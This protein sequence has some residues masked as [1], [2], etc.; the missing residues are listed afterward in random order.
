MMAHS[1]WF[2][3]SCL[4]RCLCTAVIDSDSLS[5]ES[6]VDRLRFSHSLYDLGIAELEMVQKPLLLFGTSVF[7]TDKDGLYSVPSVGVYNGALCKR[8]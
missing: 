3:N 7:I 4:F 8:K 2:R 1:H 5:I 6:V